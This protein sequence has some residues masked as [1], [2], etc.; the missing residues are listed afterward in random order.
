MKV[1][2]MRKLQLLMRL[3]SEGAFEWCNMNLNIA[4]ILW[5]KGVLEYNGISHYILEQLF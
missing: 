4:E 3:V 1:E 2:S 5:N